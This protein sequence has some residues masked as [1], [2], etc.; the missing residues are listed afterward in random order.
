MG[1]VYAGKYQGE[2]R[3][4]SGRALVGA[5]AELRIAGTATLATLYDNP[6]KIADATGGDLL[7]NPGMSV[8]ITAAAGLGEPGLDS[9]ANLTCYASTLDAGGAPAQYEIWATWRGNVVGPFLINPGGDVREPPRPGAVQESMLAFSVATQAELD[10]LAAAA[11]VA[12]AA[13]AATA[14][15]ATAALSTS[16]SAALT[17]EATART[18]ADSALTTALAGKEPSIPAG[19]FAQG[20]APTAV[21][22][23]SYTAVPKD[24]VRVD[25]TASSVAITLPTAPPDLT[26]I[27]IKLVA[28]NG[29]NV[30]TFACGGADRINLPTGP[31]SG[32]LTLVNQAVIL[33]YAASSATW[34]VQSSDLP[35]GQLD[36]RYVGN[37]ERAA[38]LD[39]LLTGAFAR[40][41]NGAVTAA[42]PNWQDGATGAYTALV[43]SLAFPGAVD[44][45]KVTHVLGGV[46]LTYTQPT[47]TRDASGA[48]I[49]RPA[50]TVA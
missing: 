49:V 4:L 14:A 34:V 38:L 9:G 22:T 41:A 8:G 20:L 39:S 43:L 19:T 29:S 23:A 30:A 17:A 42:T 12:D 16:T 40:D 37:A 50:I 7:G 32:T 2:L 47:M 24:Y 6:V 5:K 13:V 45:Y 21:K 46:T 36:T 44:S 18:A 10:A 35:L 33:Q 3:D 25:A 31:T 28:T 1:S 15:A 48:V 26:R 11:A 27:G